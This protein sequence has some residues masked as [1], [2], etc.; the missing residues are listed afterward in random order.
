MAVSI[1]FKI[2]SISPK[3]YI[4]MHKFVCSSLI[5]LLMFTAFPL[6]SFLL[7]LILAICVS[8]PFSWLVWL[9][10]NKTEQNSVHK[11][12]IEKK[13]DR[14]IADDELNPLLNK[15]IIQIKRHF[16]H[17]GEQDKF[18]LYILEISYLF[19]ETD[20][21]IITIKGDECYTKYKYKKS[22]D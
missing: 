14:Y 8:S 21:K 2:W 16:D 10:A 11:I 22:C 18:L 1:F 20:M 13:I 19:R 17:H 15:D 4:Y 7:L 3:L 5:I 12:Q 6:M 9:E